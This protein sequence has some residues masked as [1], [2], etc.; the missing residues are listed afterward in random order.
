MDFDLAEETAEAACWGVYGGLFVM[1]WVDFW[2]WWWWECCCDFTPAAVALQTVFEFESMV[3]DHKGC[4][5]MRRTPC[6]Q[7]VDV[8]SLL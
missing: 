7:A 6:Y 3:L 1:M 2:S 8:L 5:E 4:I